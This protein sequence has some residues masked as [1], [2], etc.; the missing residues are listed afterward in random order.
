M[1]FFQGV[2]FALCLVVAPLAAAAPIVLSGLPGSYTPGMPIMFQVELPPITDLGAYNIDLLLSSSIGEPGIDYGF[3][4]DQTFPPASGY[5]F[6][7][8]ANFFDAL[9]N[10]SGSQR[11][12][13]TDFDFSGVEVGSLNRIVATV[14]ATT[15]PA[16]TAD[17]VLTIDISTLL[18]DT[19]DT[20]PSAV[21]GFDDI[22][23]QTSGSSPAVIALVPEPT[24]TVLAFAGCSMLLCRRRWVVED[25]ERDSRSVPRYSRPHLAG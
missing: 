20:T 11:L 8:D 2:S 4:L 21:A 16:F 9:N 6:P 24:S 17:L 23:S 22:A 15:S 13:L 14:V 10:D 1:V 5:V 18:L 3:D 25:F 7:S 12:T 19:P